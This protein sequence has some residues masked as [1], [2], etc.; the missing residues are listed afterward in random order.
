MEEGWLT[1]GTKIKHIESTLSLSKKE[2]KKLYK[3]AEKRFEEASEV[4]KLLINLEKMYYAKVLLNDNK[5]YVK[6][7]N[8]KESDDILKSGHSQSSI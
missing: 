8:E 1:W 3:I 4:K 6:K 2:Q 7:E 5:N